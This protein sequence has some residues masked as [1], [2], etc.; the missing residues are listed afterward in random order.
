MPLELAQTGNFTLNLENGINNFFVE[1]IKLNINNDINVE[2]KKKFKII[3]YNNEELF[4]KTQNDLFLIKIPYLNSL[5]TIAEEKLK[6]IPNK[7]NKTIIIKLFKW[8]NDKNQIKQKSI[9]ICDILI[10]PELKKLFIFGILKEK[11]VKKNEKKEDNYIFSNLLKENKESKYIKEKIILK[12]KEKNYT[13]E[14]K[15]SDLSNFKNIIKEKTE[16]DNQIIE[17]KNKLNENDFIN[18]TNIKRI[19]LIVDE[20]ILDNKNINFEN[21]F[22]NQ[23]N[24]IFKTY[25]D[26]IQNNEEVFNQKIDIM[27]NIYNNLSQSEIKKAIDYTIKE[28]SKLKEMK[29]DI[30]NKREKIKTKI[31]NVKNKI[32]KY[33]LHDDEINNYLTILKKY[34]KTVGEKIK[35]IDETIDFFKNKIENI[36]S[37]INLFP[38]FDLDFNLI[39]KE[40]QEKYL[41][42]SQMVANNSKNMKKALDNI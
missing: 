31:E 41:K 20:K 6:D 12:I 7:M 5:K 19:Q 24:I 2:D 18:S 4:I 1:Y 37:Y 8:N 16:Y 39:E 23:M 29:K 33:E 22:N 35:S 32:N 28:I 30:E 25:K 42:F 15:E 17:I 3:Q 26:L 34:Q 11:I 10:I 9:N 36:F 14:E 13:E 40:N 38:S 21:E 27:K